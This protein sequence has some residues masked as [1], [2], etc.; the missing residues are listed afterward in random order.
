MGINNN[1]AKKQMSGSELM[2]GMWCITSDCY[3]SIANARLRAFETEAI[4]AVAGYESEV[5]EDEYESDVEADI[6]I[7]G[8][9]VNSESL[10][11]LLNFFGIQAMSYKKVREQIAAASELETV[12]VYFDSPGGEVKSLERTA[13]ETIQIAKERFKNHSN[14]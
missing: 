6:F 8:A 4:A 10:S 3:N 7:V 11:R 5:D 9:L 1:E 14:G 13:N 2:S 12:R